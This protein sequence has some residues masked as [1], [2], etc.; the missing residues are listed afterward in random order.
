MIS[1]ASTDEKLERL[2]PLGLDHGINYASESFVDRVRELTDGRGV[3]VVL[4]SIGGKNLVDSVEALA[5]RGTLVSVGVAG[6]AG[7]EIEAR[8]LWTKNNTLRGVYLGGAL[9]AEYPRVHPMIADLIG[10]VA[11]GELHVEIDRSFPLVE[12]ALPMPTWKGATRSAAWSWP[13]PIAGPEVW[14]ISPRP[15]RRPLRSAASVRR[16]A[17]RRRAASRPRAVP[18]LDVHQAGPSHVR[19]GREG[20]GVGGD[21]DLEPLVPVAG[22]HACTA[23]PTRPGAVASRSRTRPTKQ[24]STSSKCS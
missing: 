18:L 20:L 2:K 9:L 24:S 5:Y 7:S 23:A 1:T 22:R 21:R 12:A 4:D 6:R 11:S 3:D 19:V 15:S 13:E 17:R 8:S 10:R 14:G 16:T